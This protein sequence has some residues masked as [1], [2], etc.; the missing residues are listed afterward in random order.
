MA[1]G[2]IEQLFRDEFG[3]VSY[4]VRISYHGGNELKV[5]PEGVLRISP[6]NMSYPEY[7][8]L[9]RINYLDTTKISYLVSRNIRI[10]HPRD[11]FDLGDKIEGLEGWV[12]EAIKSSPL[13]D[14]WIIQIRPEKLE[15]KKVK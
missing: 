3:T 5:Y 4:G 15:W 14:G 11:V 9:V 13:G 2:K 10:N 6:T 7:G 8:S 1:R 12:I